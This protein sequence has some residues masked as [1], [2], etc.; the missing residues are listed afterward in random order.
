MNPLVSIIVP[1]YNT[2]KYLD[3]CIKSVLSQTYEEW[4]LLLVDDG[5][6]DKSSF[7]CDKYSS[8]DNRIKVIHKKNTGVSD[9][10]NIALS[11]VRGEYIAFLDADDYWYEIISLEKLIRIAEQYNLDI[12]RGEYKAVDLFGNDLF[13]CPLTRQKILNANKLLSSSTF[14]TKIMSGENFL[15]LSLF[16]TRIIGS[17]RFNSKR[18]FL[19]DM[20]FFAYL[21]LQPL[22][23]MY[24]PFRF[25]A[26]RK[27][28][29]SA[30]NIPKIKNLIDSFSMTDVFDKCSQ[31]AKDNELRKA[32]RYNSI[33]MYYWTLDTMS[34]TPYYE[35]RLNLIKD[36][37]L[38][39]L[40]KRVC[41]W[42]NSTKKIYPLPIYISPLLGIYY[43]RVKYK[44][45]RLLR[46]F[47]ML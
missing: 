34:Q 19:E 6:T 27:N 25:Y 30:S 47:R 3:E 29:N 12:V 15:V 18:S 5:S 21:L 45:G 46:K 38:T 41:L 22:R 44:L 17:L 23:C 35:I 8:F 33:M 36:L 4:E 1:I 11:L 9:S 20:E 43:F 24:I 13:E 2:E 42:A 14:Y 39:E 16:K 10:R 26:Y 31:E 40:N 28:E 32:Y 7:I 37:S